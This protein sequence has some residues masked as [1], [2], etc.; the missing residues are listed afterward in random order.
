MDH[1]YIIASILY[2]IHQ[3]SIGK[4]TSVEEQDRASSI[5]VSII[6]VLFFLI[7]ECFI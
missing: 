5:S 4:I 7:E 2:N 1:N 3:A 6:I